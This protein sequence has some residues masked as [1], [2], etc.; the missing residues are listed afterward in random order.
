MR[1]SPTCLSSLCLLSLLSLLVDAQ[2]ISQRQQSQQLSF[3]L[4]PDKSFNLR[5]AESLVQSILGSWGIPV[6]LD[7]DLDLGLIDANAKLDLGLGPRGELG[8]AIHERRSRIRTRTKTRTID[9][10]PPVK[11]EQERGLLGLNLGSLPLLGGSS[12]AT[13][14]AQTGNGL[15]PLSLGAGL[16]SSAVAG[17]GTGLNIGLA[18]NLGSGQ[19]RG[20]GEAEHVAKGEQGDTEVSGSG[21][22]DTHHLLTLSGSPTSLSVVHL[23]L[24]PSCPILAR[25]TSSSLAPPAPRATCT[26]TRLIDPDRLA[27]SRI[28]LID[29]EHPMR[30]VLPHSDMPLWTNCP[31]EVMPACN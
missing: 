11:S 5:P 18:A 2:A 24:Y 16:S 26:I 28:L 22:I 27:R 23:N 15:L 10:A 31:L 17:T 25:Q 30:T 3:P 8:E 21:H 29:G 6:K 4:I 9:Q 19:A 12:S 14:P 1:L 7:L 20:W 13:S